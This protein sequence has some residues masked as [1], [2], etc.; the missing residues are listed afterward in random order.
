MN[1]AYNS[2]GIFSIIKS[3]QILHISDIQWQVRHTRFQ[4]PHDDALLFGTD[5][6]SFATHLA[7]RG[8][9]SWS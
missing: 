6:I 3:H 4:I 8:R 5:E 1:S 7:E 2:T 9:N